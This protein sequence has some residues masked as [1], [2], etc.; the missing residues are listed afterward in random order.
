MSFVQ[1][2]HPCEAIVNRLATFRKRATTTVQDSKLG[3]GLGLAA[4]ALAG[5]PSPL[6]QIA[7]VGPIVTTLAAGTLGGRAASAV[8]FLSFLAIQ[9]P[10]AG[11]AL[12]GAAVS[13]LVGWLVPLFLVRDGEERNQESGA[14][15]IVI[16]CDGFSSLDDAYGEGTSG[17]VFD[18]LHRA[19]RLETRDRDVVVHSQGHELILVLD[20]STPAIAQA[21]MARVERRFSGWLA[22]AGYECNLAVGLFGADED[23]SDSED[24]LSAA[25]RA[26]NGPYVD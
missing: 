8:G 5:M 15:A 25:R 14:S 11:A 10:N 19:L 22:D 7:L 20:G 13:L 24:L 9:R 1:S 4:S 12:V 26:Q 17:H 16:D 6:A 2:V 23:E 18:L 21:V 3:F